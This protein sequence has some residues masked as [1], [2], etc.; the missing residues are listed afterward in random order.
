MWYETLFPQILSMTLTA[1]LVIVLV[2]VARLA[3]RRVPKIFSYALWA[4]VLFRLVC[5][6]SFSSP[7]SL[8]PGGSGSAVSGWGD[9]YVGQTMLYENF[10]PEYQTA[11]DHG[12][13]PIPAQGD[14]GSYV[15]TAPDGISPPATVA[16]TVWPVLGGIWLAGIAGML[17]YSV[18]SLL[19]LRRRLVGAVRLRD[20]IW[21]ADH[22]ATPFVLGVLRPRIYLPS[23]LPLEERSY[24][25]LHEQTHIRRGDHLVKILAFL[26]LCVHWFNPLVWAAFLF[27]MRD[28]E[29]CCDERVL[30]ELGEKVRGDYSASLLRLA[31]GRRII[32]GTPLAFG[33]G[34]TRDRVQNVLRYKKPA[35]WVVVIAVVTVSTLGVALAANQGN[36][37]RA[38]QPAGRY[39][40][41]EILYQIPDYDFGYILETAPQYSISDSGVL[42]EKGGPG[43]DGSWTYRG[44]MQRQNLPQ[45]ELCGLFDTPD[46]ALEG[47]L[48]Q[49]ETVWRVDVGDEHGTFYLAL[50][51]RHDLLMA[52]GYGAGDTAAHVRW[53]FRLEPAETDL[54]WLE[55]LYAQRTSYIGDNSKV[56]NLVSALPLPAGAA[57]AGFALHTDV[58]P[59][60][61][62]IW[63]TVPA[64]FDPGD[65]GAA[66][67][68][69]KNAALVFALVENAGVVRY[70][71]DG[72]AVFTCD[73]AT[74][75][76]LAGCGLWEAGGSLQAFLA[77]YER[78]DVGVDG[79]VGPAEDMSA[80]AHTV[81]A[82][83]AYQGGRNEYNGNLY[84]T[85]PFELLLQLPE[86]WEL[87]IPAEAEQTETPGQYLGC[88][89]A[90]PVYL[91]DAAGDC[92]G[93]IGFQ[94]FEPA[95]E[96]IEAERY[97]E[98]VYPLLRL[99]AHYFL[100][101][102]QPLAATETTET[103]LCTFYYQDSVDGVAAAA[104]PQHE[105]PGILHYDTALGCCVG[106]Q[107]AEAAGISDEV[108]Q[109]IAESIALYPAE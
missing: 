29:M 64:D 50:E 74:A 52:V 104:W 91:Y 55:A 83:P 38:E 109:T 26:V 66:R 101:D 78:L 19:R 68:F 57:Y 51:T 43:G 48:R 85:E 84:D 67:Q 92:V 15:V 94:T 33:E 25:I 70:T 80:P 103:A 32:A 79:A 47:R 107:F 61:V 37:A 75:E 97:Y 34:D 81:I 1:S 76:G 40:T 89:L 60:G 11:V 39:H 46:A 90:T 54:A 10:R 28:M 30:R 45:E 96:E 102:Y 18:I 56:G 105:V 7:F 95:T 73:R 6:V 65:S 24:I 21:L 71:V 69:Y 42:Y 14:S 108:R 17:A 88:P 36:L 87:A 59:Y 98:T 27:S 106:I 86:G 58:E 49:V 13:A 20:N 44:R 93:F 4:V 63:L 82:F 8:V 53:L 99:G 31:T 62:D 77:L 9:D 100:L 16:S 3:L 72:T 22:I 41:A 35:A 12:I 23:A 5:P 2:L